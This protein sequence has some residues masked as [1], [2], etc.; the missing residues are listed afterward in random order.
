MAC[1]TPPFEQRGLQMTP[2]FNRYRSPKM[3][4]QLS[5]ARSRPENCVNQQAASQVATLANT[6]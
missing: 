2:I 6:G 3:S 1:S 5:A 4:A